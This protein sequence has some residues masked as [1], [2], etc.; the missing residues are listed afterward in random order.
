MPG[1]YPGDLCSFNH[2]QQDG[3][4][5]GRMFDLPPLYNDPDV[6]K[7]IGKANGSMQATARAAKSKTVP[8]GHVFFGQF[9][10]HDITLDVTS[11]F[12]E[13]N[14]ASDIPNTRT[15]TLDLDCV[16][17]SGPEAS[18]FLYE[19]KGAFK[20]AKLVHGKTDLQRNGQGV[21]L[22]GDFRNDENRIVSQLQLGMIRL[23]NFFCD[24]L[25]D[26]L[27]GHDL[28][29]AARRETTW[30]YQWA[31]VNDFLLHMCGQHVVDDILS[32]GRH[33]Y[34]PETPFIPVE[35]SVAAYRFG[36][37][38]APQQIQI[39]ENGERL[40]LFFDKLG[41][42]EK[43]KSA[44]EVVDW[45]EVFLVPGTGRKVQP[46]EKCD[47]K[48][49]GFLLDLKFIDSNDPADRSLA[50]RNLLRGQ[51]FL[52]PSGEQ[53]AKAMGRSEHEIGE[54]T[55]AA[56]DFHPALSKG[57]PLWL[58][59]LLEGARLGRGGD[60]KKKGEGLGPVGGRIVA[61]VLIGLLECDSRSWLATNRSWSPA[62]GRKTIGELLSLPPKLAYS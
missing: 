60:P 22:I 57:T 19:A 16:Y 35:F 42:F 5:F 59:V 28:F 40:N 30:H 61:E 34:T 37:S 36:H 54:V 12:Q 48:M 14:R 17:G 32:N 62:P 3:D 4:R 55:E 50:A 56:C 39:Q 26:E 49:A 43:V 7:D 24:E 44:I 1:L 9:I 41:S 51:S 20:G 38:M 11:S 27:S 15:P 45:A 58:Y 13:V 8:V 2:T 53:V 21:A 18:N 29:E 23:H 31:V 33:F 25:G 47:A 46:A 10:D 52:L 6:L